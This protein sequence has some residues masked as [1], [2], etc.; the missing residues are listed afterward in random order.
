MPTKK[1]EERF[2][3]YTRNEYS[4]KDLEEL[5]ERIETEIQERKTQAEEYDKALKMALGNPDT[6]LMH[7]WH[8]RWVQAHK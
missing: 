4:I 7:E 1:F 8:E 6:R 2:I 3:A 5:E